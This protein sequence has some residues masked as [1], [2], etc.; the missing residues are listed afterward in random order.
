[1]LSFEGFVRINT[2]LTGVYRVAYLNLLW[3]VTTLVGL[4]VAGVGPAS[5]ALAK[6][7][8]RWFRHGETP[9]PARTFWRY[10]REQPLGSMLVSW[11]L[12]GAG[13]VIVTNIFVGATSWTVQALN[14]VA[15][16]VLGV[17][18]SYVYPVMVAT[19]LPTISRQ[20]AGALLLGFGSLH[21]TVLGAVTVGLT[22]WAL[23]QFALPLLVLFG[24]GIPA[25]AIGLVT[26]IA[27]R[28]LEESQARRGTRPAPGGRRPG[29][30]TAPAVP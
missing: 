1:M 19:D 18:A 28:D 22:S 20:L 16:A 30:R 9:P 2:F 13:A 8:D 24:V 4:G 3:V 11:I 10:A 26:R 17:A 21:W 7:V 14:I 29:R 27:Y 6:Y 15:L 23:A 5:Y 25:C 12:L